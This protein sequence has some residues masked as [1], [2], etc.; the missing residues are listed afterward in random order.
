MLS[1]ATLKA[2]TPR[3][4]AQPRRWS[5][6]SLPTPTPAIAAQAPWTA[7]WAARL[8]ATLDAAAARTIFEAAHTAFRDSG[9]TLGAVLSAAAVIETFYVDET[10]LDPLDA[11][12]ATLQSL[13]PPDDAWPS[14]ACEA[15]VMACSL[16][17]VLRDPTHPLLH[18]W[19][20]RG[21]VLVRQLAPGAVRVRLATALLQWHLWRGEFGATAMIVDAL[22]GLDLGGLRPAEAIAWYESLATHARF[23]GEPQRGLHAVAD[24]LALAAR[25]G[26]TQHDYALHAHGAALAIAAQD[27]TCAQAHLDAMR[28]ALDAQAQADQTHYWHFHAGLALLQGDTAGALARARTTLANSLEIGGPYRSASHRFSL[29]QVLLLHGEPAAA[30]AEITRALAEA[31]AIAAGL[32]VF[33]CRLM[34]SACLW[35]L[36]RDADALTHLR[37]A[38][39]QAARQDFRTT[40]GWWLPALVGEL[41]QRALHAGIEVQAACRFVRQHALPA[42]ADAPA[43]WPWPLRLSSF[44][45]LRVERDGAP[46]AAIDDRPA[47][48][49]LDLL[50]ALLA[51]GGAPLP[52]A[53]ALR[54]LWPEAPPAA[55]R[56]A[57]D[58]ALLRLRRW[59]RDER[60]LSLHG[61]KLALD[62]RWVWTDVGALAA[63]LQR[64]GHA[65]G[66]PLPTLLRWADE[67]LALVPAPFLAA[68]GADWVAAAR[69]R[70]RQRFVVT[71]AQLAQA[72][73][74]LDPP[75]A[76][77]LYQRALDLDPLAESLYRRLMALHARRGEHAEALRVWQWCQT[78]LAAD[79]GIAPGR[80]T[81]ALARSLALPAWRL[82]I[83]ASA[84]P[85]DRRRP[86]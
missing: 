8:D 21:A 4:L 63:L 82:D 79:G 9:D 14:P 85:T 18:R 38:L 52:V 29:G 55:Q 69:E 7:Y 43:D 75:A 24:A 70:Y 64:I 86:P 6:L 36:G 84:A 20:M 81:R 2:R 57:F 17:I 34:Q 59:L 54:W 22:P 13:L 68:D 66:V 32:L 53:S 3:L 61:G 77:R 11:W 51:H 46:L 74:A 49:P 44:G 15:Q 40:A 60:V 30:L 1:E 23:T 16:G 41:V 33:S 83:A 67:L 48:R 72:L 78:M 58:V 80:E 19:A 62:A 56:K 5:A 28:P 12:I 27:A 47:Q 50:R 37:D 39:A 65:Q 42:P 73:D 35:R 76:V 31:E 71:A 45:E 26:L 10:A 25:H